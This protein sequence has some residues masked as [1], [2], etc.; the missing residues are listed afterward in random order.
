MNNFEAGR[1][2]TFVRM[3]DREESESRGFVK[4]GLD[5]LCGISSPDMTGIK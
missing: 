3:S 2:R 1:R 5:A 4:Q